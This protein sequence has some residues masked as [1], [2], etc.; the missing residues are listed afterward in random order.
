MELIWSLRQNLI[1][2]GQFSPKLRFLRCEPNEVFTAYECTNAP[3]SLIGDQHK[4]KT[5]RT[6]CIEDEGI[7]GY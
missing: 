6:R 4:A 1:K 7:E 3:F 5:M 2:K